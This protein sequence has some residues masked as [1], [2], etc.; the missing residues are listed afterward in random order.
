[1]NLLGATKTFLLKAPKDCS[2]L[3]CA[4]TWFLLAVWVRDRMRPLLFYLINVQWSWFVLYTKSLLEHNPSSSLPVSSCVVWGN[5]TMFS[6]I[7]WYRLDIMTPKFCMGG[8]ASHFWTGRPIQVVVRFKCIWPLLIARVIRGFLSVG[9]GGKGRSGAQRD[10]LGHVW[11]FFF[12]VT[13]PSFPPC[14]SSSKLASFSDLS[15]LSSIGSF[16]CFELTSFWT[17]ADFS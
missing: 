17:A 10:R 1:M 16:G 4:W 6:A 2:L 12:S 15:R 7:E 9:K 3:S 5:R 14:S 11:L 13:R 8:D